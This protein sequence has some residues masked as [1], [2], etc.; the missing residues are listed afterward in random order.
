MRLLILW[1]LV[2][3]NGLTVY[4]NHIQ[5]PKDSCISVTNALD[6]LTVVAGL[7][8]GQNV[9]MCIK[10][11]TKCAPTRLNVLNMRSLCKVEQE[12]ALSPIPCNFRVPFNYLYISFIML[13][14]IK[15]ALGR[16]D[17]LERIPVWLY[18]RTELGR[19]E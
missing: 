12:N 7:L 2:V 10:E 4:A 3:V 13:C 14:I 11:T 5:V 9:T 17:A 8:N 19:S 15:E 18:G 16:A 6:V 1:L